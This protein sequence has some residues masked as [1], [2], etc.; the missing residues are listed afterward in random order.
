MD[1]LKQ[2]RDAEISEKFQSLRN[3]A[4]TREIKV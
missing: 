2:F 1:K 3:Q 4:D